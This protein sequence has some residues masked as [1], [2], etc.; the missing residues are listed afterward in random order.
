MKLSI[1]L[2]EEDVDFLDTFAQQRQVGSRS[3]VVQQAVHLLRLSELEGAYE[4]AWEEWSGDDAA[5]LWDA[6]AA[7]GIS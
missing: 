7:D 6:T 4:Q 1:S 5:G 3:A 2:S